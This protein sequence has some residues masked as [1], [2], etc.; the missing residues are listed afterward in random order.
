[1]DLGLPGSRLMKPFSVSVTTIW[2]TVGG[3]WSDPKEYLHLRFS[4]RPPVKVDILAD[5][6]EVR[7]LRGGRG[8]AAIEAAPTSPVNDGGISGR[9]EDLDARV[10]KVGS[11]AS[12]STGDHPINRGF[13]GR[14]T[15]ATR[16]ATCFASTMPA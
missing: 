3:R 13:G 12:C 14:R 1:M 4:G 16:T 9:P 5:E 2:W 7:L 10:A 15:C 6:V 8:H 11:R